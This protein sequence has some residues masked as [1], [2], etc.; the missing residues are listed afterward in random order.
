MGV[1]GCVCWDGV[2]LY[3]V[4]CHHVALYFDRCLCDNERVIYLQEVM[5]WGQYERVRV[6]EVVLNTMTESL[7]IVVTQ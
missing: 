2:R 3:H 1:E 6:L 7:I 4:I 5:E